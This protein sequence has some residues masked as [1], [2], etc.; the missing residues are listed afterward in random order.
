MKEKSI[1]LRKNIDKKWRIQNSVTHE[2]Q[3]KNNPK[4]IQKGDLR[5]F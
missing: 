3:L 1:E 2:T 5:E 4:G